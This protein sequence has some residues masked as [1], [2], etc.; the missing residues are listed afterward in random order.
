MFR[1]GCHISSAGGY[2][3]MAKRAEALGANTFAFFTRNPRGGSAKPIEETDIAA[4]H[5][6]CARAG[7][8]R[9]VAHAPYT[10]NPCAA[11]ANVAEFA[12]MAFSDDL[13]RME[14]TPGQ[15]YNFHPGSHVGQ[16][17]DAGIALIVD[18]LNAVLTP[19]LRTTVL[20]ETMA[21]K[22]SEVGRSFEELRRILDGITQQEKMGVCLDTCHLHDAGYDLVGD[23]DGVLEQFD[24]VIGLHRLHAVHLND[25]MNPRGARKDRHERIGHGYLGLEAIGRIINHPALRRLPFLLETP[26]E[27]PGFGEE[28]ALL[29]RLY[30]D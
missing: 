19:D 20:L 8:D 24:R 6:E 23:L 29:R 28:I 10:L 13:Q 1:I 18:Q 27:L 2:L 25:S 22:G 9:L 30:K 12:R 3:A 5:A 11:K 16:G 21:G 7:I 17:E 14:H 26:N 4:F 15:L